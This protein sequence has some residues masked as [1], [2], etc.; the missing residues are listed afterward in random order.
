MDWLTTIEGLK[1]ETVDFLGTLVTAGATLLGIVLTALVGK[2]VGS[3][4]LSARDRLD[5]EAEWRKHAIE[6]TRLETEKKI[7]RFNKDQTINL[8]PS[9]LD[10]LAN[11][12]DLQELGT[13]S[14]RQLYDDIIT[15]RTKK[16]DRTGERQADAEPARARQAAV[17]DDPAHPR[18]G[19]TSLIRYWYQAKRASRQT[20]DTE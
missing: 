13:R 18:S 10:F 9:I 14:P 4:W 7:A 5:K 16:I 19:R 11:Y 6:L 8:R 17:E 1:P 12:R 3:A 2:L 20:G 15:K